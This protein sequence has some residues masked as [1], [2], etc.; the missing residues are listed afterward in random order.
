MFR[1]TLSG[2]RLALL[3][4]SVALTALPVRAA[5]DPAAVV[6]HYAELGHAK[7]QDALTTAETLDKAIDALI[8]TPSDA[9]LK[10]AREAWIK[11]RVPYQQT[12]VYRFGNPIVDEWEG[13]VNAWPLDEGLIDYVDGSY[14]TESDENE[15]YTANII[16]N[17]KI[18][19]S[20]EEIDASKI[21]P[22]LIQ[23]LAEAGEVEANV[24][25]GYHAIEF[26]LWGQDLNGTGPG[27][28][29]R[30]YTDYDTKNCTGGNCDRRADYLKAASTLLVADLKE[31]TDN[32]AP[33]GEAAKTVEADPKKGLTAILTG[34]GSLSYG[35]LAG[36][37]MKLGLLLHDPEEE[38]DCFSDNTYNS[39]LNDAIGIAAAYS[40]EYTTVDGKKLTGPSLSQ[41]VA[42]S[43]KTL[44]AE[45]KAKLNKTLDAMHVME[46]RGQ[47]VEA[48]DQMIAEGNKDGNAVVQA[49]ID[50]LLD[51]TKTIERVIAAL[52]LGKI[53]LEGS[54][55]LDSPNA[56]FK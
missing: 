32:W 53:Q 37:R 43:D 20:G 26:L 47:T 11:A 31:M 39:H 23:S 28:G 9:T 34:M 22:E 30:P 29:N 36:E 55:S 6:K 27:A 21:T 16:A 41:L 42:A 13:K 5:T 24:T 7:Y 8:A 46:K 35:E 25:T 45:M 10:A 15:L 1:K 17:K 40:G 51:Q 2:A 38:H 19:V 3:A 54:D 50:G 52:D 18:K 49:A 56:V 12:E 48:Y 44:D 33:D 14:G 4:A